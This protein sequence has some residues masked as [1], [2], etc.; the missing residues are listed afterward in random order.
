MNSADVGCV[1]FVVAA[2]AVLG[3]YVLAAVREVRAWR[4]TDRAIHRLRRQRA[5]GAT[6]KITGEVIAERRR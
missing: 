5:L 3:F 1:L 4:S 2:V 6:E